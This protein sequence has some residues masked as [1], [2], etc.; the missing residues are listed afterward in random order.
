MTLNVAHWN[1]L[2]D[3]LTFLHARGRY[4]SL[5]IASAMRLHF[6]MQQEDILQHTNGKCHSCKI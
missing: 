5:V 3:S 1:M 2:D 6:S 4:L